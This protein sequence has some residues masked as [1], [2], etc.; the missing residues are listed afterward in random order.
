MIHVILDPTKLTKYHELKTKVELS[1]TKAK[2]NLI[3]DK[4]KK[5]LKQLT[6]ATQHFLVL[7]LFVMICEMSCTATSKGALELVNKGIV[8]DIEVIPKK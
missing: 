5:S 3:N 4:P 7:K 6:I 1:I 8:K 2:L